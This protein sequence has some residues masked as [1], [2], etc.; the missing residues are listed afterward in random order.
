LYYTTPVV[1]RLMYNIHAVAIDH[2]ARCR[3]RLLT[4]G[5]KRYSTD[6]P[7]NRLR[8]A[9]VPQRVT[10]FFHI[11]WKSPQTRILI[12]LMSPSI[13][14]GMDHSM[15]GVVLPAIREVFNLDADFAAWTSMIYTLPFMALMP[16]YGRLGDHIGKRRLL[17]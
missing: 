16:L 4:I 5:R 6:R 13:L 15:F 11:D 14:V 9:D 3:S 7:R 1:L 10:S 8:M 2:L 12:G 17:L